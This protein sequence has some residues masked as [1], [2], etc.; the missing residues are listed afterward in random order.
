[1][2]SHQ[3]IRAGIRVCAECDPTVPPRLEKIVVPMFIERI[4]FPPSTM[5]DILIGGKQCDT[6]IRRPDTCWIS[7]NRIV[8]LEIDEHGHCDREPSCEVAKV[9]DQTLSVQKIYNDATVAH[10]RFNPSEFDRCMNLESRVARCALDIQIFLNSA[11]EWSSSNPYLFYYFYP[12]KAHH[13][14][15]YV[16]QEAADAIKVMIIQDGIFSEVQSID[17]VVN[18][19]NVDKRRKIDSV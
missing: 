8:F 7:H 12:Q 6:N 3:R 14:I 17:D 15:E 10:F 2:L 4:G 1:M 11:G 13:Q 16:L 19:W 5:D 9:I 18:S